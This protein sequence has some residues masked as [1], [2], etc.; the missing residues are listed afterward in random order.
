MHYV[1]YVAY[2]VF[3][4]AAFISV[5]DGVELDDWISLVTNGALAVTAFYAQKMQRFDITMIA[6]FTMCTSVVWHSS[7]KFK[8]IDGFMSRYLAYY[9]FGTTAFPPAL[10]GPFML[11]L[12]LMSTYEAQIDELY[13]LIPLLGIL[14]VYRGYNKTLTGNIVAAVIVGIAGVL[15]YRNVEWHSMWHVLGA[16]TVALTIEPP[17]RQARFYVKNNPIEY[18]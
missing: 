2:A 15:C 4:V 10:I 7:G 9:A 3:L 18:P 13:I 8:D 12:V 6:L 17:K 5:V 11:F 1:Y 16:I 14:L